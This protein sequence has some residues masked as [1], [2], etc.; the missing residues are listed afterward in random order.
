MQIQDRLD[1]TSPVHGTRIQENKLKNAMKI[2]GTSKSKIERQHRECSWRKKKGRKT[3]IQIILQIQNPS[4]LRFA[5]F[6]RTT[7]SNTV[8]ND[9]NYQA[10]WDFSYHVYLQNES[11]QESTDTQ[12]RSFHIYAYKV[13]SRYIIQPY[14][15][16]STGQKTSNE[17]WIQNR[18]RMNILPT[19]TSRGSSE[20]LSLSLSLDS[21]EHHYN[22][23]G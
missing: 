21:E 8:T 9:R 1:K 12:C 10:S 14:F 3:K 18:E 22:V 23:Q 5:R 11:F 13:V 4:G 17:P 7:K 6:S 15:S 16:H 20:C 19:C 2:K